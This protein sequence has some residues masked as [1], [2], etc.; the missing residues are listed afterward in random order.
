MECEC[1]VNRNPITE[2]TDIEYCA[3]HAANWMLV[4]Q[5]ETQAQYYKYHLDLL[6]KDY[7]ALV[8]LKLKGDGGPY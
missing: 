7:W 2:E 5:L 1:K 8:K 6:H 4:G 3:G